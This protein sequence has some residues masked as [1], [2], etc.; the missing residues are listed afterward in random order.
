VRRRDCLEALVVGV[1]DQAGDLRDG[2]ECGPA[3]FESKLEVVECLVDLVSK[4]ASWLSA[5]CPE[6]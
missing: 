2:V 3:V 4:S 5:S 1:D 6:T